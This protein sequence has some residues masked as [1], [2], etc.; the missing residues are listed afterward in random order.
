MKVFICGTDTSVGKTVI[1]S[2]LAVHT[3]ATYFKPIQTGTSEGTDSIE[4][5]NLSRTKINRESFVYKE[6]LSPHLAAKIENKNI[7]I[8]K[9]RLPQEEHLIV[10]GAGGLLVPINDKCFIIDLIKM[11]N[12]PVILVT[13]TKLGTINHTLLSIE[14]L[15]MRNIEILGVI[16]N[17][18]D[19]NQS[20]EAIEFYGKVQVVAEFP[21]LNKIDYDVLKSILLPE[22]FIQVLKGR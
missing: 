7:D 6:A 8:D 19:N 22:K 13:H 18:Q 20:K 2:W 1:S 10:E 5:K 4:V 14:A 9:I 21:Y 3:K 12:I 11:L 16:M 17:G 15:R